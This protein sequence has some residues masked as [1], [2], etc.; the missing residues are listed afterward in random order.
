MKIIVSIIFSVLLLACGGD[1][2][3]GSGGDNGN[4]KRV[5]PVIPSSGG[6]VLGQIS[7]GSLHTC[8]L[9]SSGGVLCW[10]YG[11]DGRIGT[12]RSSNPFRPVAVV[13]ENNAPLSSI[14]QVSVKGGSCAL[15]VEGGV[16]CWGAGTYGRLGNG[17]TVN[18]YS[19]VRVLAADGDSGMLSDV[20]QIS[21]N[22]DHGC[23][24]TSN[25]DVVCW[26]RGDAGQLGDGDTVNKEHPVT[27]VAAEESSEPLT[28]I[29][30]IASGGEHTCALTQLGGVLC[31]GNGGN[32]RLGN[33]V[34][35]NKSHPVAVVDGDGNPLGNVV[36]ISS[37]DSHTCALNGEGSIFCWGRGNE[38]TTG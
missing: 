10:G 21:V 1:D 36:Q 12:G 33:G 29:V 25:G 19:A 9:I 7:S 23:A 38:G 35:D 34:A 11:P 30:Q 32:G 13:D 5:A 24:L 3:G 26:G 14:V 8:S 4:K 31:W 15:D 2:G 16:Y 17:D 27:V 28:G 20:I 6:G 22:G 37:G 18:K